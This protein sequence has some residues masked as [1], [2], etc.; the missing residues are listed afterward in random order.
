MQTLRELYR[1]GNGPSS[2]HTIAPKRAASQFHKDYPSAS[3]FKVDLYGSLAAT[4]K[5]HLT[6][7]AI[8]DVLAPAHVEFTWKDN[9]EFPEHPNGMLFFAFDK[10]GKLLGKR[11]EFSV[12]GG[13]LLSDEKSRAIYKMK[14][15]SEMLRQCLDTGKSFWE[16]VLENEGSQ[17]WDFMDEVWDAM[18]QSVNNGLENEGVIPGGLGL[19]RK[20]KSF[21]RK[22]AMNE[23]NSFHQ[24]ATIAAYAY[25]VAEENAC[26]GLVVTSPTC[27]SS[28]V[29]PAVLHYLNGKLKC[30]RKDILRSLASA[31]L[32]GNIIKN[33]A[34]I[35]GA[36][37]GCQGEIGSA[38]AMAAAAATQLYG[39]S[40]QQIEYAAEMGLEHHLGLTCDPVAGLVQIPC[41]ERNAH[42][43][44]RALSCCHFALLSDGLHRISFDDVVEV[45]AETGK[46]LNSIYRETAKGGLANIYKRRLFTKKEY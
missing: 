14:T 31:G 32:F 28:G 35:S 41:I 23:K 6:D 33:N 26:G 18:C 10:K 30:S 25:A 17:I 34:S 7:K 22:A 44:S 43:A 1:I 40:P 39:G 2:S 42:A 46:N 3:L 15:M 20:A 24:E 29:L 45:M 9:E 36:V 38:C 13:A 12:G 5:G 19:Y 16:I 37:V 11:S 27:G 4:G 21:Y 8:S